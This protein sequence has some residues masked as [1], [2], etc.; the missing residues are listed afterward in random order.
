VD[1]LK[2]YV[3]GKCLTTCLDVDD[4]GG[5]GD[6]GADDDD[7]NNNNKNTNNLLFK[8]LSSGK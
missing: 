7:D 4:G 6:G 1:S 5:G 8:R 2:Y 3:T